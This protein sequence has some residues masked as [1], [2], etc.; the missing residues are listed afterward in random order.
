MGDSNEL[1]RVLGGQLLATPTPKRATTGDRRRMLRDPRAEWDWFYLL[2]VGC[3][4][5]IRRHAMSATSGLQPDQVAGLAGYEYI[6]D[7]A[8]ALEQAVKVARDRV[9]A[10]DWAGEYAAED[11]DELIGPDELADYLG[12]RRPAIR[13]MRHRGQLPTPAFELSAMPIWTLGAIR[14]WATLTGR[15]LEQAS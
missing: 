3:Q 14:E 9:A 8:A 7:W 4:A 5:W 1:N 12:V 15:T 10:D 6:D 11:D 13:Q 2:D